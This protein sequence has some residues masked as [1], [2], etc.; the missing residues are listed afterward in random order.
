MCNE[1]K[2]A[3]DCGIAVAYIALLLAAMLWPAVRWLHKGLH[4]S[5]MF[6]CVLMVMGVVAVNLLITLGF[7]LA[8]PK[9]LQ[10]FVAACQ[11]GAGNYG[12][13]RTGIRA[14]LVGNLRPNGRDLPTCFVRRPGRT[15]DKVL[16]RL[17]N[18]S[19]SEVYGRTALA[20]TCRPG[21]VRQLA[22]GT[23]HYSIL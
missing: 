4:F 10:D 17:E 8:V 18:R 13:M 11:H 22:L 7:T 2:A 6:S 5:W 1:A 15:R 21:G 19:V 16:H 3:M 14:R 20:A 9:L 12:N 23:D